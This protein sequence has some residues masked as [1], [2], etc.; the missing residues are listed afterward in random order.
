VRIDDTISGMSQTVV[1]TDKGF[2]SAG[3]WQRK[4]GFQVI[5]TVNGV[6][7]SN[8]NGVT[9]D[10]FDIG[11]NVTDGYYARYAAFPTDDTWYVSSGTW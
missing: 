8:D 3:G 5:E 2:G 9:W 6:I 1:A 10:L 7:V 11:A 4:D